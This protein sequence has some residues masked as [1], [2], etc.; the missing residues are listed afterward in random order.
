MENVNFMSVFAGG[1]NCQKSLRLLS[2]EHILEE[3]VKEEE[4]MNYFCM[5]TQNENTNRKKY[6][7]L[8][9]NGK[10]KTL[11][12]IDLALDNPSKVI[13]INNKFMVSV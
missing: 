11:N 2:T 6:S 5:Y 13:V 12:R 1:K 10:E 7:L 3:E 9:Y 4:K 8:P